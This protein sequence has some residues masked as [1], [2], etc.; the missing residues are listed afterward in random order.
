MGKERDNRPLSP[1]PMRRFWNFFLYEVIIIR[2]WSWFFSHIINH[3]EE[4]CPHSDGVK[5]GRRRFL[6]RELPN[7]R[8][9]VGGGIFIFILST[10]HNPFMHIPPF[11]L[12]GV[13]PVNFGCL[14]FLLL[15][16]IR[17]QGNVWDGMEMEFL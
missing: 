5:E 9:G 8:L 4:C 3:G 16:Y 7:I 6:V 12:L 11:L 17:D 10:Y 14:I 15:N 13:G 1:H 2:V